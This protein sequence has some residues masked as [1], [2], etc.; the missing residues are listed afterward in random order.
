LTYDPQ[1][2]VDSINPPYFYFMQTQISHHFAGE[3]CDRISVE[4]FISSTSAKV[5]H[6]IFPIFSNPIL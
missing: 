4:I 5:L 2:I 3:T 6:I 1:S